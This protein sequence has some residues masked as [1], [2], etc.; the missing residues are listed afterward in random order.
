MQRRE[1]T[2]SKPLSTYDRNLLPGLLAKLNLKDVHETIRQF[3][4]TGT[5]GDFEQETLK[6]PPLSG[7]PFYP[8]AKVD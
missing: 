8:F 4:T 3:E 1:C 2:K 5:K 6:L 7:W